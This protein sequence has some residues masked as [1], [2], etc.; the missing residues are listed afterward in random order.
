[1]KILLIGA[2]GYFGRKLYDELEKLNKFDLLGTN[3]LSKSRKFVSIDL[4]NEQDVYKILLFEPNVIIWAISDKENEIF[5]SLFGLK[6]IISNINEG[7]K[8]IYLST[9]L[10]ISKDQDEMISPIYRNPSDYLSNYFNGKI[11]GEEIL[12]IHKNHV[13]VRPGSI[14][15]YGFNDEEDD[16]MKNLKS[17]VSKNNIYE[18]T[19]NL[20]TSFIHIDDLSKAIIELI[21]IDFKGI[22]NISCATPVSY[23]NF[24]RKIAQTL[25]LSSSCIIPIYLEKDEY[26]NLD[27][28]KRI[29]ILNTKVREFEDI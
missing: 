10:G 12:K 19:I 2:S 22:I 3:F 7:T 29:K 11:L 8:I 27:N 21:F 23:F 15:G 13:I 16:R 20:F 28:D 9:M 6:T 18:R 5:L 17:I 4:K 26:R 14:F 24:Y 25:N 1:M